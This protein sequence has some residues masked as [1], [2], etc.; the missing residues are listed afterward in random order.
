MLMVRVEMPDAT[1][2]SSTESGMFACVT[3]I[4]RFAVAGTMLAICERTPG[5]TTTL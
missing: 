3:M 1:K 5:P 2:L 4:A